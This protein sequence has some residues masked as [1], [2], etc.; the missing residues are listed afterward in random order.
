MKNIFSF[1]FSLLLIFSNVITAQW[2]QS[3]SLQNYKSY[4]SAAIE[5]E[6][7]WALG[8]PA[9]LFKSTDAGTNWSQVY[10]FQG[11]AH[12]IYFTDSNNGWCLGKNGQ[13]WHTSNGGAAWE[14]QT[15]N[16]T[17]FAA[18]YGIDFS[19]SGVGL[20]VGYAKIYK[21][22][23]KVS[24]EKVSSIPS[25]GSHWYYDVKFRNATSAFL[26]GR[27]GLIAVS[28]DAGDTW[29]TQT[30]VVNEDLLRID[31]VDENVGYILGKTVLLKTTDGGQ[32]W[33]KVFEYSGEGN[34][35]DISFISKT[36]GWIVG[37]NGIILKTD[38]GGSS[39]TQENIPFK[40]K[41][42]A[43][44]MV[45]AAE[46][47]IAG[48]SLFLTRSNEKFIQVIK[49]VLGSSYG[50]GDNIEVSWMS[51]LVNN[52][53][54]EL[55]SD[56]G[57]NFETIA[58]NVDAGLHTYS[59]R[60]PAIS[61]IMCR[62]KISDV[63]N[64]SVNS[65]SQ[66]F[67]IAVNSKYDHTSM[68][69]VSQWIGNNGL[70]SNDGK[71]GA[72]LFW[73]VDRTPTPTAIYQDGVVWGAKI[74]GEIKVNG[75]TYNQGL[76]AGKILSQGVSDNPMFTKYYIWKIR[77]DYHKLSD[78]YE[79]L[80]YKYNYENWP[81]D[82]GA[83]YEDVN[84]D[85]KWTAGVDKPKYMG[86]EVLWYVANDLDSNA[87][88]RTYGSPPIGLEVQVTTYSFAVED[89]QDVVFKKYK[90]INKSGT[91]ISDMYLGIWSDPDLGA[92]NDDYV[93]C[94]STL[95]L[96]YVYNGNASDAVFGVPPAAG[97]LLLQGPKVAGNSTDS[98]YF[99]GKWIT[100][101][102]NLP[103]SAF[104]FYIN[105]SATYDDPSLGTYEGSLQ[106]YDNFEGLDKNG[107]AFVNPVTGKKTKYC[108]SGDPVGGSGWYEGA[109]WSGGPA[110]GDRRLL[111]STG[112]FEFKNGDVQEI[113][114]AI[115][116]AQGTDAINSVQV[117]KDKVPVVKRLFYETPLKAENGKAVPSIFGLRQ[118]YPNPFNPTT[119]IEY[120]VAK[121]TF[122]SLKVYDVLG[123]L[124]TTLVKERKSPGHYAVRFNAGNLASG[125]YFYRLNA[126]KF[127][128]VKKMIL[129][130]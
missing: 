125:I 29:T 89:L 33:T 120:S 106:F 83:P 37:E 81:G 72:G 90:F 84:G 57:N 75:N 99:D 123:R 24:W 66:Q 63:D 85:G 59:F 4:F 60:S 96:G 104:T 100:G 55:S 78:P 80:K 39:F 49:P 64:S 108:L 86:D 3:T 19:S 53:S 98:A 107:N 112:P 105:G 47:V 15:M 91:D 119:T 65:V 45:S 9:I 41:L 111:M 87:S 109:G 10:S 67:I 42:N 56:D 23:D 14:Q 11:T 102:K 40:N 13:I 113:S 43:I 25:S 62:I 121:S 118:N 128:Q 21:T 50:I 7:Y 35:T 70:S 46:G 27:S 130:K 30:Q 97:Y 79:K 20:V 127:T 73:P 103:M 82:L 12:R 26:C 16:P 116:L 68:N 126:G 17:T 22:T 36:E 8:T 122:V 44:K 1:L 54:I 18:L 28:N 5:G 93:G 94:D 76:Q 129:M 51:N 71:G 92:P 77:D 114:F 52:V 117:L 2:K 34:F 124:V 38:D 95:N 110:P 115:I 48:D 6:N 88:L 61:S 69:R 74:N 31:F 32:N 101:F 58:G